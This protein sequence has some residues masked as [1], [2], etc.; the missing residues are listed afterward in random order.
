MPDYRQR[1]VTWRRVFV[2]VLPAAH[3]ANRPNRSHV[4]N[5]VQDLRYGIR[6]LLKSPM[7]TLVALVALA[8][9]IGANS[10]MFA[11]VDSVLLRPIP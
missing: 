7:F 1:P 2:D 9:G 3:P 10:A 8:L 6:T 5:V 11:I 4:F